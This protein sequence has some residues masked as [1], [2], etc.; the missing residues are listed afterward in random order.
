M[1]VRFVKRKKVA[2]GTSATISKGGGSLSTGTR[3]ARVSVGKRGV[4]S[5]FGIPGSGLSFSGPRSGGVIGIIGIIVGSLLMV[6]YWVSVVFVK[7]VILTV[8]VA[9]RLGAELL[10]GVYR[11]LRWVWR[12]SQGFLAE[13]RRGAS[14]SSK[15]IASVDRKPRQSPPK[16]DK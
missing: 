7:L 3:G 16:A 12:L 9:F 10:A 6:L 1:G 11:L 15:G 4:R 13:R 2:P 8:R 5:S 14:G